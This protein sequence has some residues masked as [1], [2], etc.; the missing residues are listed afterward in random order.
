M[1]SDN[2]AAVVHVD[3]Y[4]SLTEKKSKYLEMAIDT[5]NGLVYEVEEYYDY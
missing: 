3:K 1:V 4:I 2:P 5:Y